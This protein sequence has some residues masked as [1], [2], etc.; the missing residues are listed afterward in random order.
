VLQIGGSQS[1]ERM[2]APIRPLPFVLSIS[3]VKTN[4]MDK[5]HSC[6]RL[7]TLTTKTILGMKLNFKYLRLEQDFKTIEKEKK[8]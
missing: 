2:Y 4:D 1:I 8:R 3:K 6:D 5:S 7:L